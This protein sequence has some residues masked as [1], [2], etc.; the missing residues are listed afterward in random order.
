MT[1]QPLYGSQSPM[2]WKTPGL[3]NVNVASLNIDLLNILNR[4]KI[5]FYTVNILLADL[6]PKHLFSTS[7]D[8]SSCIN[9]NETFLTP[10]RVNM[11]RLLKLLD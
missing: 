7:E 11:S 2:K 8:V 10:A 1:S 3:R 4:K 6:V 9:L 5:I